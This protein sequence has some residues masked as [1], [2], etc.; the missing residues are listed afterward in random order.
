MSFCLTRRVQIHVVLG[1][2]TLLLAACHFRGI[3]TTARKK[4]AEISLPATGGPAEFKQ[5]IDDLS[6]YAW[7]PGH[8]TNGVRIRSTGATKD[9][10][11]A[12]GPAKLRIVA[13]IENTSN[14]DVDHTPSGTTFK[15]NTTYLMWVNKGSKGQSQWGF[16]GLDN[17]YTNNPQPIGD[18]YWCK[19]TKP[20]PDDDADF[21][22]CG[23]DYNAFALV[24]KA[25]AAERPTAFAIAKAGWIACDPDCC[26]GLRTLA[27]SQ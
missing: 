19:H 3:Q 13:L 15:A 22:D 4:P 11:A 20:S 8:V 21:K 25:Q 24:N 18:L 17:T 2:G 27:S 9:I 26:T 5:I 12:S 10:K 23:D 14:Q 7:G 6:A 16:I 1:I